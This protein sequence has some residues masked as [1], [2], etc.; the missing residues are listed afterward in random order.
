MSLRF[1]RSCVTAGAS[2]RP[3]SKFSHL[4]ANVVAG[5]YIRQGFFT[6]EHTE[7]ARRSEKSKQPARNQRITHSS[8]TRIY[9]I[10][11]SLKRSKPSTMDL[12]VSIIV[13]KFHWE[14]SSPIPPPQ[15]LYS[16]IYRSCG[17]SQPAMT[18]VI[19]TICLSRSIC[20]IVCQPNICTPCQSA[21]LVSPPIVWLF[22]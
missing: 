19:P 21:S 4:G 2:A 8:P 11:A 5:A 17:R 6:P 22:G 10:T 18:N 16:W 7:L 1:L 15:Q 12:K 20:I 3:E 13:A 14:S 9:Q